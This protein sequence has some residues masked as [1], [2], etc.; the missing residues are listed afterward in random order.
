MKVSHESLAFDKPVSKAL[1]ILYM[2][3]LNDFNVKKRDHI[4]V[5]TTINSSAVT[6]YIYSSTV[7]RYNFQVLVLHYK[8]LISCYF[9][10]KVFYFWSL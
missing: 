9:K 1:E 4:A 5:S 3:A 10:L 8:I 2:A 6:K 7:V